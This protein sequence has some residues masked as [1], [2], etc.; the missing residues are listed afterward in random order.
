MNAIWVEEHGYTVFLR[1]IGIRRDDGIEITNGY[2]L[3]GA[4]GFLK[5]EP[6]YSCNVLKS[7]PRELRLRKASSAR[8]D[9]DQQ[10]SVLEAALRRGRQRRLGQ[11]IQGCHVAPRMPAGQAAQLPSPGARGA[12]AA[13]FPRVCQRARPAAAASSGGAYT[14]RY[15]GGTQRSSV[16]D[17]GALRAG[18]DGIPN[19]ALK[20][21]IAARP[22]TSSCG[23]TRLVWRPAYSHLSG[24]AR[25]LS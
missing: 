8:G 9:Q 24:S 6:H 20:I 21:A 13:L 1:F 4:G 3:K 17:Q 16:E 25:G 12:V 11:T 15:L 22:P 5:N 2:N 23:C 14:G 19:S 10:A 7:Q 18:P